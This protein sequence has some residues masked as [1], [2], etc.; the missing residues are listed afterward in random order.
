RC[1]PEIQQRL[2]AR[3]GRGAR[4]QVRHERHRSLMQML[5]EA[6][7]VSECKSFVP[8]HRSAQRSAKLI[9]L[10]R[11]RTALVENVWRIQRA[12]SQKLKDRDVQ[13]TIPGLSGI[14]K[15]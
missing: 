8:P 3:D 15:S 1:W 13:F 6:F 12:I 7:V 14:S 2:Y 11:R 9:S 5:P 10:E 4:S